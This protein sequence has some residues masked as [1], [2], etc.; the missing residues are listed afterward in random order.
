[1]YFALPLLCQCFVRINTGLAKTRGQSTWGCLHD[2]FLFLYRLNRLGPR[3][4]LWF[5]LG[6]ILRSAGDR[7]GGIFELQL[8]DESAVASNVCFALKFTIE[9]MVSA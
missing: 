9:A 8:L 2:A 4:L 5:G 7:R 1:M 3:L 6:G